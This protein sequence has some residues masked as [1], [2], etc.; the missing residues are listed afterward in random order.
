MMGRADDRLG[1]HVQP[2]FQ[3]GSDGPRIV[4]SLNLSYSVDR[5]LHVC[6]TAG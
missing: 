2:P 4:E 5:D 1:S 3:E 6:L